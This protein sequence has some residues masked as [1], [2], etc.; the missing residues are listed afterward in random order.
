MSR[1]SSGSSCSDSAVKPTRSQK[2][3]VTSRRSSSGRASLRVW[4]AAVGGTTARDGPGA[5]GGEDVASRMPHWL[6]KRLPARFSAPQEGQ[7][8]GKAPPQ[9][10]QKRLPGRLGWPQVGQLTLGGSIVSPSYH[11]P[12]LTDHPGGTALEPEHDGGDGEHLGT[13]RIRQRERRRSRSH[14]IWG[15]RHGGRD[16][17]HG[18]P[19]GRNREPTPFILG[20]QARGTARSSTGA[21]ACARWLRRVHAAATPATTGSM[22]WRYGSVQT[23]V[24]RTAGCSLHR[25]DHISMSK[26][27]V[28]CRRAQ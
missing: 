3:A 23:A 16:P 6:Q 11:H 18:A 15:R 22:T 9:L 13:F 17:G 24:S 26:R 1:T 4:I 12:C 28:L 5:A 14:G 21:T 25:E 8:D 19:R 7:R 10:E 27:H 20:R 2:R